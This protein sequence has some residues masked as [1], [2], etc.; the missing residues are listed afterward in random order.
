MSN[1]IGIKDIKSMGFIIGEL[2]GPFG[3]PVLALKKGSTIVMS[4]QV[5]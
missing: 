5:L 2:A 3:L 4:G 1:G